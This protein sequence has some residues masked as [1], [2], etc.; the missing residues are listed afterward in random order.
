M[1]TQGAFDSE[2]TVR[3]CATV[4][5]LSTMLSSV[6]IYNLSQNIQEDDLQHLQLFTEYGR[7]ALADCGE[8]PF[9]KL[10]FL[11]RDWSFPYE[12]DYGPDGGHKILERRL[13]VG[14]L[15]YLISY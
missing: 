3:E 10:Q 15:S 7:L 1:D 13:E 12:A 9:Q 5:A 4:F 8:K 14:L 11:V 2:S 6:Q